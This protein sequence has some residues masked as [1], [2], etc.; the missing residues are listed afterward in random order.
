MILVR[1]RVLLLEK[2]G[3]KCVTLVKIKAEIGKNIGSVRNYFSLKKKITQQEAQSE[4]FYLLMGAAGTSF[5]INKRKFNF[6]F[7]KT[8]I[9]LA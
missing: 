4:S 9:T 5:P 8:F 6:S 3:R 1:N 2:E 7:I